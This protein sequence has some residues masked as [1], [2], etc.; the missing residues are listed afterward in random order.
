MVSQVLDTSVI[1]KWFFPEEGSDRAERCLTGLLEGA[2]RVHVPS[3]FFYEIA[4]VIWVRRR[5]GVGVRDARAIWAELATLPLVVTDWSEIFPA[6]LEIAFEHDVTAYDAAFV[7][8]ARRLNCDLI[9][10]DQM[11]LSKIAGEHAWVKAL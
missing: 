10:A 8:L 4:N 11:L 7:A 3:S 6:A 9:T 1:A 5:D 2:L